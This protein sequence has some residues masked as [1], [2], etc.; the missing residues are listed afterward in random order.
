M[1]SVLLCALCYGAEA[2]NM[3]LHIGTNIFIPNM[4]GNYSSMLPVQNFKVPLSNFSYTSI[5]GA[6]IG[7]VVSKQIKPK[8]HLHHDILL[9]RYTYREHVNSTDIFA[10]PLG[11]TPYG[12]SNYSALLST[13][14]HY[15][16]LPKLFIGI[17]AGL[18]FTFSSSTTLGILT[19]P[20]TFDKYSGRVQHRLINPC[21]PLHI[22]WQSSVW[23]LGVR[24]TQAVLKHHRS[25]EA[26][27]KGINY[28]L[29]QIEIG[30][31]IFK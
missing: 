25:F 16:V 2:Q 28:G 23:H 10:V 4:V 31:R 11:V 9:A 1:L 14:L 20:T 26:A 8:I 3:Y 17:G 15:R 29:F 18:N 22:R 21:I 19:T 12:I 30:H 13:A 7:V 6:Q 24:Y 5:G 27:A